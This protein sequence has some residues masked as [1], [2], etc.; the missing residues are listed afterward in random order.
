MARLVP[1]AVVAA[2]LS[3][4]T[5]NVLR[6]RA[7]V[8]FAGPSVAAQA[9]EIGAGAALI[10][11]GG[12]AGQGPGRWLLPG[13][14]AA[15][16]TTEWASPGAPDAVAF[17][18][19]L[20]AVLAASPLVLASRWRLPVTRGPAVLLVLAVLL[21]LA[22]A[23]ISGPLASAAAGPRDGGC[24]DCARDLIAVAHD[25][26][27]NTLLTRIGGQVTVVAGLL[28]VGWLA[29]SLIRARR[30]RSLALSFDLV[31]DA[32]AATFAAAVAAG[33]AVLLR[34]GPAVAPAYGS[35][36]AADVA[37]LILSAA[38]AVPALRAARARRMVARA[39]VAVA[40][41]PAGGAAGA[42]AVALN[43]PC[44]RVA[45]PAP[46]GGWRDHRGQLVVLPERDVTMVWDA[47][48]IVAALVHSSP[49]RTDHGS[50]TGAVSAARLLLDTERI[51][52]G[53]LA[54]VNDLRAA[55]QQ[56]AEAADAAR[57]S[58][59]RDLHDGAQQRLVALRYALG[60]AEV[61]ASRRAEPALSAR[62]ADA[63]RAAE[64]ALADL[65]E[66]AHGIS[67]AALDVEG[68]ASAVRSAAE[69]A[70]G[71]VT[72]LE[73]PAERLPDQVE[74]AAYRFIA[75]F[76]RGMTRAPTAGLSIAVRQDGRDVIIELACDHAATGEWPAAYLGDR[77][78]AVGGQLQHTA[79]HG[80]QRLIAVLPCE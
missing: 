31:A 20:V 57:A 76:L 77:L 43:D 70:P 73:L 44:L 22:G 13:A 71:T 69:H 7:E 63:D 47:G 12:T 79:D 72:I 45:Y 66:L 6:S 61:R 59:E 14:G 54:R 42:L 8:S 27:L 55:R 36:A 3:G 1:W 56:V 75:D 11:V 32:A 51:E 48:E 18:A 17:T 46:A 34:L 53:A 39:A 64:Q 26:G 16:L 38:L 41:G 58:L 52:A 23:V 80:R 10:V 25:A 4:V 74:R 33:A 65:R 67:A 60:L 19:G 15:W 28:A 29:A 21:A 5:A 62:L 50:V 24:T 68:F 35:R 78:A 9:L 49:A 30:R 37:L 40:D 2:V